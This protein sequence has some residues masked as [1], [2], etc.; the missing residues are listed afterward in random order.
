[1]GRLGQKVKKIG[2]IG[3]KVGG[4]IGAMGAT[5][6]MGMLG[7]KMGEMSDAAS[8][9]NFNEEQDRIQAET[10]RRYL[11]GTTR[12]GAPDEY[13]KTGLP[14]GGFMNTFDDFD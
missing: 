5:I 8:M 12:F 4:A 7:H 11:E 2:G 9:A 14:F 13:H 3:L 10:R 1:M 6:G